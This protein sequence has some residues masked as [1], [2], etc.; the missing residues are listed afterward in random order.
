[1][2][3]PCAGEGRMRNNVLIGTSKHGGQVDP[4]DDL[5]AVPPLTFHR[6]ED[7]TI[8]YL[9]CDHGLPLPLDPCLLRSIFLF[10]HVRLMCLGMCPSFPFASSTR[11]IK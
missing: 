11:T 2:V 10:A 3:W 7:L 9:L 4:A 5:S 8:C 6:P 1:M